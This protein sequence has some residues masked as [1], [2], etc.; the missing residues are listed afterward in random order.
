[1]NHLFRLLWLV[2]FHG[3][4]QRGTVPPLGP[5]STPFRVFPT[6]LDLLLHVNNGVYL[7]LMDLGRVD[8]MRRSG[9]LAGLRS[10]HWYPVVVAETIQF[11]RP[12]TLFQKFAIETSVLGW[13]DKAFLL[14]QRFVRDGEPLAT[15]LVRARF[16][17]R[18]GGSV[19]PADVLALGGVSDPSPS[20]SGYAA[21][22]NEDQVAWR[23][24][25]ARSS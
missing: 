10:R 18:A 9:L 25:N 17:A 2:L 21:R 11:R 12:L 15:A 1:M 7:S 24:G 20:L 22:W 8:L 19:S 5:C 23:G 13:D 14:E 6:D 3:P 16:L 4:D